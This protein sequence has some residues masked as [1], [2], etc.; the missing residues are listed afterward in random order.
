LDGDLTLLIRPDTA[1]VDDHGP[2]VFN[3]ILTAASFRGSRQRITLQIDQ[4]SLTFE[5][6]FSEVLPPTGSRLSLSITPENSLKLFS[7]R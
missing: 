4:V 6:P 7:K 5:F 3:G 2:F 1:R